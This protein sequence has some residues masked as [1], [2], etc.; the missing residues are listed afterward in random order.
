[1]TKPSAQA[2]LFAAA[3]G[4][5][6]QEPLDEWYAGMGFGMIAGVDEAGRGALAGPVSA[7]AVILGR[8]KIDGL[9]DSKK[10]APETRLE[11]YGE[12]LC[13]ARGVG[14]ALVGPA[15]IDATN[16][17]L[18]AMEAMRLAVRMLPVIPDLILVDGNTTPH[19]LEN[20]VAIVKGDQK[21]QSIMASSIVAKVTRDM[22][23]DRI[24]CRYPAFGFEKHKG[25][26][27]PDHYRAL[28]DHGVT[29][30]HR[31]T[32]APCRS[33]RGGLPEAGIAGT[34]AARIPRGRSI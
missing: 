27:V 30:I 4:A 33:I 7:G 25:Y 21:S 20:A 12:I 19:G 31:L 23:M 29:D 16:I 10:L 1:M 26:A 28:A 32:F 6:P 8:E 17:L 11:L 24:A 15:Q 3:A 2:S 13:K 5:E 14:I 18:A 34:I 22:Y 9:N